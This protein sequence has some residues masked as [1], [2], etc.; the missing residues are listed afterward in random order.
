MSQ[1]LVIRLGTGDD[2]PINYAVVEDTSESV[3]ES[4]VLRNTDELS[5]LS[6]YFK[7]DLIVLQSCNNFFFKTLTY[8]KRFNPSMKS[9]IPFMIENEIAS[10]V[11]D[12]EVVVLNIRGKEV[13]IMICDKSY[14]EWVRSVM[15]RYALMPSKMMVDVFT[16]PFRE[17]KISVV[18]LA[19]EFVFRRTQ[20]SGMCLSQQLAIKYFRGLENPPS[21]Y[22]L[23]EFPFDA[24][25]E[26]AYVIMPMASMAFGALSSHITLTDAQRAQRQNFLLGTVFK[27]WI[28]VAAVLLAIFVVYY[29]TLVSNYFNYTGEGKQLKN[30]LIKVFKTKFPMV[31]KVVNPMAQFKQ[32]TNQPSESELELSF[33]KR[34]AELLGSFTSK[35]S[36]VDFNYDDKRRQYRFRLAYREFD[37]VEG[38]KDALNNRGYRADISEVR[39]EKDRNTV[40]LTVEEVNS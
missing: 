13:D 9:S 30:Q 7:L 29:A 33:V 31:N 15:T 38:I 16:L 1:H 24:P 35:A 11:D 40:L 8:P 32:L 36:L 21:F 12:V 22:C 19:G 39:S 10:D 6:A 5:L 37:D 3:I 23:S 25:K 14:R 2:S 20:F 17:G 26:D 4:G 28:K 18:N 34:L 27:P